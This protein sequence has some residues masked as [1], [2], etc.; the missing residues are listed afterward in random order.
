MGAA[1]SRT[2]S[3]LAASE[4]ATAK[5]SAPPVLAQVPWMVEAPSI[6]G[7]SAEPQRLDPALFRPHEIV[8]S[9]DLGVTSSSDFTQWRVDSPKRMPRTTS[10]PPTGSPEE[11]DIQVA[12]RQVRA[13]DEVLR[14]SVAERSITRPDPAT[15]LPAHQQAMRELADSPTDEKQWRFDVP[16]TTGAPE[17]MGQTAPN[18]ERLV[19]QSEPTIWHQR[20]ASIDAGIHRHH[21]VI[22]L[23][24]LFTAAG[25]MMLVLQGQSKTTF[26]APEALTPAA[27]GP[28]SPATDSEVAPAPEERA[29]ATTTNERG[30]ERGNA[31][32]VAALARGPSGR[33]RE[34][35]RLTSNRLASNR[36][37]SLPIERFDAITPIEPHRVPRA[38]SVASGRPSYASTGA[39]E[40]LLP[41]CPLPTA[42]FTGSV[43]SI[44]QQAKHDQHESS[45]H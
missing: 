13:T 6:S 36:L 25:L 12:A 24:A 3:A 1:A 7:P 31:E 32:K 19:R 9:P 10:P 20:V 29:L 21:R 38:S 8:A 43:Q 28:T 42:R 16:E 18:R 44:P 41:G 26:P 39:S 27:A 4:M 33:V 34:P 45:L 23:L 11:A 22:V 2:T 14:A 30:S 35:N 40:I 5:K 37:T 17:T 15:L